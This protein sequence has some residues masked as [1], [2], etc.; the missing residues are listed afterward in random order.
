MVVECF[1]YSL[2]MKCVFKNG[3]E[4]LIPVN[5]YASS[6]CEAV[7]MATQY[8]ESGKSLWKVKEVVGYHFL[9]SKTFLAKNDDT[10]REF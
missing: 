5:V 10:I 8:L 3:D 6:E 1:L 2:N 9:E 4:G 7:T